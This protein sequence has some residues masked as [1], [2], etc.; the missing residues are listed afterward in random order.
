MK[1]ELQKKAASLLA[2]RAYSR[3]EI[4]QK[5]LKVADEP[6]VEIVLDR[7]EH[8][9]LLNDLDYAYN[10]ALSRVG[11]EGWGPEKIRGALHS[12]QVSASDISTALDQIRFLVGDDYALGEY[13]K[14]YF[15]KKG[16]P[17]NP[18]SVRKLVTHLH[19]RGYNW[20]SIIKVLRQS[21]PTEMMRYFET[22]D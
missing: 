10:F 3:G 7:L 20:N 19:R 8:L 21:L 12:R 5:L 1:S 16:M 13:L 6:V 11:R 4:R 22:G 17:E 18:N 15:A 14:R 9:K 2:R